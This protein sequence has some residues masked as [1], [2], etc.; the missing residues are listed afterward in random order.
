MHVMIKTVNTAA[1]L[2]ETERDALGDRP[3]VDAPREVEI[4]ASTLEEAR[5]LVELGEG[6]VIAWVRS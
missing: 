5:G 2:S 4:A 3:E 6:E 1:A